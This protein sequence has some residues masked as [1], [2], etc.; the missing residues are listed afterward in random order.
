MKNRTSSTLADLELFGDCSRRELAKVDSLLTRVTLPA[1]T[2]LIREGRIGSEFLIIA[3]GEAQVTK[4]T[5]HGISKIAELH[6][7]EFV[8]EIAL[9]NGIPR[10]ATVTATT[11]LTAY[12][13]TAAEFR[14]ILRSAPGAAKRITEASTFR[15]EDLAVAA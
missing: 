4:T 14:E 2:V 11:D 6:K 15:S 5:G 1:G 13:S 9:L 7:G 12:V 10:T 3:S 8:G